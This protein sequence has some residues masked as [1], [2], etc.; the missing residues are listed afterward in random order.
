MKEHHDIHKVESFVM[1]CLTEYDSGHDWWHI[2]RVRNT[3]LKIMKSEKT[4]SR[5]LIEVASL[6]HDIGDSKFRKDDGRKSEDLLK[7]FLES[8]GYDDNFISEVLFINKNISFSGG[9]RPENPSKEFMIVQDA[10]RLDAIGAI[11]LARAF[12]YGGFVNNMIYDPAGGPSTIRHFD[13][14]LLKLKDLMNTETGAIMAA[15]RHTVLVKFLEQFY[16][17]WE[18]VKEKL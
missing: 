3:A 13:D 1:G 18:I 8:S 6:L 12:N 15:D 5:M 7:G 9:K 10:D 16:N 11:G 4:G 14:K 17:E 2:V